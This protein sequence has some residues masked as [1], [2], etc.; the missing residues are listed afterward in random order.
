MR[1]LPRVGLKLA[2]AEGMEKVKWYGRGPHENYPDRKASAFLGQYESTVSDLFTP[3][4]IPQENG[5]R[6]DTRWLE[7]AFNN[8]SKPSITIE[9]DNPFIFS[10][11]HYD[12]SDLDVAMR[13]EYLKKRSETILCLDSEMLGL[14]NASCGP[15]TMRKY[16]VPVKPYQLDFTIKL[17]Q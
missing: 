4:L 3:Y 17:N 16:Q 2:F 10:A 9:S 14:G 13:P 7:L 1:S 11:L 6:C 8:K 5:A 15:P 12:A